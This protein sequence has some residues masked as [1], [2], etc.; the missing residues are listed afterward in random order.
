MAIKPLTQAAT[1]SA[2][3][4]S[5]SIGDSFDIERIDLVWAAA[6]ETEEAITITKDAAQGS[7]YDTV[8]RSET[9]AIGTTSACFENLKGFAKGDAVL[10]SFPNTDTHAI[11]GT[12]SVSI[13]Y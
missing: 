9:L 6:T 13:L 2:L 12:A 7:D 4:W 3:A 5:I 11:R 10:V 8:I 1:T